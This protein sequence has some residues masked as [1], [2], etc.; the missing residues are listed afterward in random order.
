VE[1]TDRQDQKPQPHGPGLSI[2]IQFHPAFKETLGSTTLTIA[3][4]TLLVHPFL[5]VPA[6]FLSL[7]GLLALSA[8]AMLPRLTAL[9]AMLTGLSALL[10]FLLH[11]VRHEKTPP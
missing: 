11:I 4:L 7:A 5:I 6:L 2:F 10:A 3:I 1:E 9:L 8:L